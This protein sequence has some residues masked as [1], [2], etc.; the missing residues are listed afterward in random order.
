MAVILTV[1]STPSTFTSGNFP[2]STFNAGPAFRTTIRPSLISSNAT[3][4]NFQSIASTNDN[5]GFWL[6]NNRQIELYNS[7]SGALVVSSSVLTWSAN[8]AITITVNLAVGTNASSLVVSGATTGNGTTT[9]TLGSNT[10]FTATTLGVGVYSVNGTF[11][12]S[13]TVSSF[14]DT[15]AASASV[16][17]NV[18]GITSTATAIPGTFASSTANVGGVTS[19]MTASSPGVA[20]LVANAG[21]ITSVIQAATP[22]PASVTA[23]VGGVTSTITAGTGTF[24]GIGE[25]SMGQRA[26]QTGP[27]T[28]TLG[29]GYTARTPSAVVAVNDRLAFNGRRWFVNTGGTLSSGSG[30]TGTGSQADG[31]A[32]LIALT[33]TDTALSMT[34]Q[35]ANSVMV[36]CLMRDQWA[37]DS[38]AP[39]DNKGN[40][41]TLQGAAHAYSGYLSA[42]AAIYVKTNAAG[43]SGHIVSATWPTS[44]AGPG[45]T[46]AEMTVI[47]VEVP[48]RRSTSFVQDLSYV[49]RTTT[50]TY[51]SLS[52]TTTGPAMIL[53]F[54]L[55]GGGI[56]TI[57][58]AHPGAASAPFT[59]IP[60]AD[61]SIAIHSFGYIQGK[62]AY[63]FQSGPGT[64]TATW[65]GTNEGAILYLIAI[66]EAPA[67]LAS[68]TANVGGI[69]STMT[70]GPAAS[71][72]ANVGGVT[73]SMTSAIA[74]Q[75]SAAVAGITSAIT[76]KAGT[77]AQLSAQVG[78]ITSSMVAALAASSSANVGG[79]TAAITAKA[80][81]FAALV[82]AVGGVTSA[83]NALTPAVAALAASV[84]A[85]SST[86]TTSSAALSTA[87]SATVGGIAAVLVGTSTHIAPLPQ[88]ETFDE[89]VFAMDDVILT[90]LG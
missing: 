83:A 58:T 61:A 6:N 84:G 33:S 54:W 19:T 38:S 28:G 52:V 41:Y 64:Y 36:A 68:A 30:P 62:V 29:T 18:G 59:A 48:T 76:T 81:A 78:G 88:G 74:A 85:I 70:A 34:T 72:T 24:G 60:N 32:T 4:S 89:L 44:V 69:T 71:S 86:L 26:D 17:G 75:L 8:Q 80:E 55:G 7:T 1:T 2:L 65:T 47:A 11:L 77:L 21:G 43:G 25:S 9:F 16:T 50:G 66:Q 42:S 87:V 12:L 5:G 23:N 57:G 13:G 90:H 73:S 49:E 46:G 79:I 63:A 45:T 82:A 27:T 22:A 10:F 15:Q 37:S 51:S 53:A 35:P 31:S 40:T 3:Y 67:T 20:S 39:T 56:P 14:D